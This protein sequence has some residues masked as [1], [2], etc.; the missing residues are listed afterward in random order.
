MQQAARFF[1]AAASIAGAA[2]SAHASDA[3]DPAVLEQGKELF[4]TKAVPACA[5]CHTLADAGSEGAIGPDL[6][7]LKPDMAAVKKALHEGVG[8]MPSFAATLSEEEMDAVS[9]YVVHATG[10]GK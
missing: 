5:V 8:V 10:G 3:P 9:S 1:L 7:E 6:D 2:F 4:L